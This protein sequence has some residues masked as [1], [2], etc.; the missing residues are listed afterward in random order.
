MSE[1]FS[2]P[3]GGADYGEFSFRAKQHVLAKLAAYASAAVASTGTPSLTSF[4]VR[5]RQGL[6]SLAA[7]D[8]ERTVIAASPSVYVEGVE[9]NAYAQAFIPAKKLQAILK[10]ADG[11]DVQVSVKASR[12]TVTAGPGSWSLALP[13]SSDYPAL[14]DPGQ[15][16]FA[17]ALREPFLEALKTVRH[18][19]CRDAG[20]PALTQ[21]AVGTALDDGSWCVTASDNTRLAR[22][23]LEEFPLPLTIPVKELDGLVRLLAGDNE[24]H[25]GVSSTDDSVVFRV[26]PVVLAMAR[27]TNPFPDMDRQLLAPALENEHLLR[28]DRDELADAVRRVRINAESAVALTASGGGL[29]VTGQDKFGNSSAETVAALWEGKDRLVVVNPAFLADMLAVH[30][31]RTAEFRL[32]K[33][34]G[35]KRSPLLLR[36]GGVT[37]LIS[38]MPPKLVG[39]Q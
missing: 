27:R 8:M 26:G 17:Q 30:P 38:Q 15:L 12:A 31:D 19:A 11:A 9:E 25:V 18:A 29:T 36:A 37:Q 16:A 39:F 20:Q 7:T 32:G 13:D 4:R 28:V 6:V 14:I 22:A 35:H 34:Q 21:V 2:E 3:Q 10:E 5:V 24:E 1:E 33:D 23:V